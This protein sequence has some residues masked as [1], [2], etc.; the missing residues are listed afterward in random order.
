MEI[1]DKVAEYVYDR[2]C[3][4]RTQHPDGQFTNISCMRTNAMK[5]LLHYFGHGQLEKLFFL[6]PDPHFKAANHR[7]RIINRSLLDEYAYVLQPGGRLYT[8]TDVEDLATWMREHLTAHPLFRVLSDE[9]LEA[10]PAA[11]LL[12]EAT[13]EGKKVARNSGQTW[14]CVVER[15]PDEVLWQ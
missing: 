12:T 1:R 11:G 6:F 4:L 2:C 13:E 5:F 7:R 15:L 9:E 10:D 3:A 8:A 14:R